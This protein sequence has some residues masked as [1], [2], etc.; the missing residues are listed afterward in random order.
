MNRIKPIK[1]N[2]RKSCE[3]D[4]NSHFCSSSML[5]DYQN[6][7]CSLGHNFVGKQFVALFY[8]CG[9]LNLWVKVTNPKTLIPHK[10]NDASTVLVIQCTEIGL[11]IKT[12]DTS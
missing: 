9:N 2:F 5:V 8:A 1:L 12:L 4:R 3:V 10:N 6:F 11:T 7:V